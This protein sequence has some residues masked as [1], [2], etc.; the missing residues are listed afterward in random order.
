MKNITTIKR[1]GPHWALR[2]L[3]VWAM[4]VI[5]LWLLIKLAI[6]FDKWMFEDGD[7]T[8]YKCEKCDSQLHEAYNNY[9][10]KIR[11]C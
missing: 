7:I 2:V 3:R 6:K 9:S 4:L 11:D 1:D 10:V 8:V 5:P